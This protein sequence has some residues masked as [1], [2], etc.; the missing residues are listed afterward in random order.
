MFAAI[1]IAG[2]IARMALSVLVACLRRLPLWCAEL[3]DRFRLDGL[4]G[5]LVNWLALLWRLLRRPTE[6]RLTRLPVL[7]WWRLVVLWDLLLCRNLT[8]LLVSLEPVVPPISV[9]AR[10]DKQ[11][12]QRHCRAACAWIWPTTRLM[13]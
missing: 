7:L 5:R 9:L 3:L 2:I 4:H 10:P 1:R 11:L 12:G 6:L 13:S 8:V